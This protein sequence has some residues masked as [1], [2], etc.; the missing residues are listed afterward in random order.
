MRTSKPVE[1]MSSLSIV[2]F[3]LIDEKN[4]LKQLRILFLRFSAARKP[5]V[6]E[7]YTLYRVALSFKF[8]LE[9]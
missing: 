2:A 6:S 7:I 3:F 8:L 9:I 1:V 4:V 5:E